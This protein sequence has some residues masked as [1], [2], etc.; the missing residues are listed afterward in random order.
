[1]L[2]YIAQPQVGSPLE[3]VWS[4][5]WWPRRGLGWVAAQ[6][7]VAHLPTAQPTNGTNGASETVYGSGAA[8]RKL[9]LPEPVKIFAQALRRLDSPES[10]LFPSGRDWLDGITWLDD[11]EG[12][13]AVAE[14]FRA[15]VQRWTR[16][17]VLPVDELVLTVGNDLFTEP[18]DLALTHHLAVLLAKLH[19]E[20]QSWRLP[21]LAGELVHIA[22][23]KR[24]IL[25][26]NEEGGGYAPK[27]GKVTVA[28]M[29]AAKGLEW[30]RVYLLAVNSYS[31]PSGGDE[32][33]Y[34]GER[35]YVKNSHNLVAEAVEQL[36][37]L[38]MG[39][40]DDF[41]P[42]S[43]TRRAR[44]EVAAERLRLLYVG[45]TRARRELIITYNTGRRGD[46]Q[47]TAPALAFEALCRFAQD[48][49][50]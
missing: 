30:D 9:E 21:D 39:T 46:K 50:A 22:Q 43:A 37:Q 12:F 14:A 49:F 5:V 20:N 36:N 45:I 1:V 40:L 23:N 41:V 32:E 13:R 10:F 35:F 7:L 28:T 44:R 34:R 11:V 33:T 48:G 6:R 38:A 27:P 25:G 4:E 17:A 2:G 24:R 29:H 18:A 26:F 19:G 3:Q 42:E 16:A 8:L 15:D 31:F 47:P